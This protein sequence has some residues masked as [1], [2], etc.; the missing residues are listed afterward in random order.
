MATQV[1]GKKRT[2]VNLAE[3]AGDATKL[4]KELAEGMV[5][6]FRLD[7]L[8]EEYEYREEVAPMIIAMGVPAFV[9]VIYANADN[10]ARMLTLALPGLVLKAPLD[11][12]RYLIGNLKVP[13]R[14]LSLMKACERGDYAIFDLVVSAYD[15]EADRLET[16]YAEDTL[17]D[18]IG[19]LICRVQTDEI[20][21]VSA[22]LGLSK[23]LFAMRRKIKQQ[24]ADLA[25]T[26]A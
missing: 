17:S 22:A 12:L 14:R 10:T 21:S 13:V 5:L 2:R 19:D 8:T 6:P 7:D 4:A 24:E 20:Q 11:D 1:T 25:K 23:M 18:Y 3:V 26:D 16:I 15:S 9:D